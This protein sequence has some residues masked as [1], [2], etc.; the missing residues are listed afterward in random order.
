MQIYCY[1][2]K[3]QKNILA[4]EFNSFDFTF[5]KKVK[6]NHFMVIE[7]SYGIQEEV[8]QNLKKLGCINILII[9]KTGQQISLLEDWLRKPIKNYGHGLQRF[10]G[11]K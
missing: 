5:I 11:G 10:L 7:K 8:L 3:K 4:G 2:P 9:T 6:K 1:D